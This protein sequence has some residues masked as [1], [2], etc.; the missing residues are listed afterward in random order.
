M[1]RCVLVLGGVIN[2]AESLKKELRH[3]DFFIYCDKGLINR[4]ILG[5][6]PDLAVG[7]FDS[8]PVPD[9]VESVVFPPEKDDTDALCGIKE[10]IKRGYSK[11]LIIGALG[12]RIDHSLSNIYLLDYLYSHNLEGVIADGNSY[13]KIVSDNGAVVKKGCRYFSLLALFGKAEGIEIK[14]AKYNLADGTI[15]SDYQY[16]VS[17]EVEADEAFIRVGKG[18]LLLCV[19]LTED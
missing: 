1:A 12:K 8:V 18:R 9:G 19:I 4:E 13:L 11:F 14:G 5:R 16:G 7:D 3:D 2:D 6:K 15:D 10:G 17:N